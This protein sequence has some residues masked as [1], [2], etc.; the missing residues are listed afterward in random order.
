MG[1]RPIPVQMTAGEDRT[2]VSGVTPDGRWLII[3]RDTGGQENPGLYL[4]APD[5]GPFK[6]IQKID[7]VRTFLEAVLDDSKTLLFR[8]NDV[9]PDS[10][11]IYSYD[12][13]TGQRSLL[14]GEP[15]LWSIADHRGQGNDLRLLLGKATGA[16]TSEYY[17]LDSA[18][19]K[20]T[21]L[22]GTGEK[23]EYDVSYAADPGELLVRTNK[24][25]EFRRLYRWKIGSDASAGSFR[26]VSPDV[27]MDVSGFGIDRARRHIYLDINDGGY[28]KLRVLDAKTFAPEEVLLP[29]D[30]DHVYAGSVSRDGRFATL[31]VESGKAPR[32]SY[33]W[34]WTS[35]TLTQWVVPS[36]PEVDLSAFVPAKLD[37]LS[38]ARRHADP[39]VRPIPEGVRAG[40]EHLGRSLS[41]HR[42]VSRGPGGAGAARL[43]HPRPAL[44]P[45]RIRPRRAQR[46][47]ERRVRKGVARRGQRRRAPE[48]HHRH[49]RLRQVGPGALGTQRQ[50]AEGRHHG[51]KLRRLLDA[52]R[53][54]DVR[55]HLRRGRVRRRH[56]QPRHDASRTRL[57]TAASSGRRSTA[58][59]RRTPK[60]S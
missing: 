27:K 5:G 15:G 54:D 1:R 55:R 45:G 18:S 8:S 33:V 29:E 37:E 25:G 12:L 47:G 7:N 22:L 20:L 24:F 30:A 41:R 19:K 44:R 58:I 57:P 52:R 49:R 17:E 36:A 28:K 50:G 46:P 10:Y 6:T 59:P 34:D 11:A 43:Q 4:Q 48:G 2:T 38:G 32:T 31:G 16:L 51:R 56:G 39:H 53:H 23:A 3:S 60:R 13:A 21:P 42:R 40:G 35:R 14:F 9:K 26:A